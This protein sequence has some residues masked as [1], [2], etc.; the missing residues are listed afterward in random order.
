MIEI[1]DLQQARNIVLTVGKPYQAEFIEFLYCGVWDGFNNP[2]TKKLIDNMYVEYVLNIANELYADEYDKLPPY[3]QVKWD[4]T[5]MANVIDRI[6]NKEISVFVFPG[7]ESMMLGELENE[8][9]EL[10]RMARLGAAAEKAL[11][12]GGF[13]GTEIDDNG[14]LNRY[15]C[16]TGFYNNNDL[17]CVDCAWKYFCQLLHGDL[18]AAQA[19]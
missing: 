2:E 12:R 13:V 18:P 10:M 11:D 8:Y 5:T 4:V 7:N 19:A 6:E 9:K 14:V 3:L 17:E 15:E 1:T 16:D